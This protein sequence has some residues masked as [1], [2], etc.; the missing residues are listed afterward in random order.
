VKTAG[1]Q[2]LEASRLL[3]RLLL[4]SAGLNR[5]RSRTEIANTYTKAAEF[6]RGYQVIDRSL[7]G[8]RGI[9]EISGLDT[10]VRLVSK[11]RPADLIIA[12]AHHGHFVAFFSACARAGIPLA[13]CYRSISGFYR[14]ALQESD[15]ALLDLDTTHSVTQIFDAFD[16]F[17][18]EGRYLALM[19]D[20]PFASRQSYRFLGY[21]VR[22]SSMPWLYAKRCGASLLPLAGNM[23]S[24]HLLGY[25][26]DPVMEDVQ[27]DR[28]QDLL[29]F[30]QRVIL[31]Q[32]EQY[33]WTANSILLSDPAAREAAL[34]FLTSVL[35]WRAVNYHRT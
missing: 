2:D 32:P 20:A 5:V 13:A 31:N 9:F 1:K 30:L 25:T 7:P 19:I 21:S 10:L 35:R 4:L 24:D 16:R 18:T 26:A 12:T 23:I 15:V 8:S 3:E 22:V 28:M 6:R 34:S 11:Y 14:K 17:R 27:A 29:G 33:A